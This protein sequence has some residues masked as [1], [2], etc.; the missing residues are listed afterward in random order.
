VYDE[1]LSSVHGTRSPMANDDSDQVACQVGTYRPLRYVGERRV[2]GGE[3][4]TRG[5]RPCGAE[6]EHRPRVSSRARCP[7]TCI[8]QMNIGKKTGE[9]GDGGREQEYEIDVH[10]QAVGIATNESTTEHIPSIKVTHVFANRWGTLVAVSGRTLVRST[11]AYL[12][13]SPC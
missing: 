12:T 2:H 11:R 5:R 9:D 4:A 10:V 8:N 13:V 6:A 3:A 7:N 1:S